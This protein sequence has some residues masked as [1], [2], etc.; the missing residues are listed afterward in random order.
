MGIAHEEIRNGN[1]IFTTT[2]EIDEES[3]LHNLQSKQ[4][5]M[6]KLNREIKA[7][8]I[9][10]MIQNMG[11]VNQSVYPNML[12]SANALNAVSMTN[13]ENNVESNFVL[14]S[15]LFDPT[16]VNLDE[17]PHFFDDTAEDVMEECSNYGKVL[18]VFVDPDSLGF[19]YVKFANV[20]AARAAIDQLNKRWFASRQISAR[21]ITEED[22]EE[23]VK[24]LRI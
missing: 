10:R 2:G 21:M 22:F 5:L 11:N 20:Q 16:T 7:G 13:Q 4:A 17:E 1:E 3:H 18:E 24:K 6:Q 15:N 14:L 19:V 8:E 12:G 23:N 9:N